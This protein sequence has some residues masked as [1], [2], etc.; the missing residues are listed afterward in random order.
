MGIQITTSMNMGS[1]SITASQ[2]SVRVRR[3]PEQRTDSSQAEAAIPGSRNSSSEQLRQTASDLE[4]LSH[5]FDRRLQFVL[6]QESREI[7]VKVIDR[8]TDKVIKVL[9]PE[10]LQRLHSGI[11]ES[12]GFLFDRTV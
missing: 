6:D 1:S 5:A 9:P 3:T 12:M 8:E 7:T 2:E 4:Q 11:R 10:E